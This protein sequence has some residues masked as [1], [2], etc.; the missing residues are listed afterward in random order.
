[1][2]GSTPTCVTVIRLLTFCHEKLYHVREAFSGCNVQTSEPVLI[3][4][5]WV[6]PELDKH[7]N[8]VQHVLFNCFVHRCIEA[9]FLM[10]LQVWVGFIL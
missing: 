3:L 6:C 1:M 2:F 4:D 8:D 5:R 7:L 9:D 10:V